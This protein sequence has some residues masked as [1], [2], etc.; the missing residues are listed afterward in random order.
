MSSFSQSG[1]L[2]SQNLPSL[3]SPDWWLNKIFLL[4]TGKPK[5]AWR[6][7]PGH[8]PFSTHLSVLVG[9][10]GYLAMVF[11]IQYLMRL[12]K[13]PFKLRSLT[14][15]H[16]LFLSLS[17]AFLFLGFLEQLIPVIIKHGFIWSICDEFS[18]TQPMEVLYYINYLFKWVEFVDTLFLVLKKKNLGKSTVIDPVGGF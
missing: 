16:N 17:S 13:S 9:F 3:I 14:S 11:A 2:Y 18:W 1:T 15:A 5:S 12:K 8:T 6:W 4:T 10:L 7:I